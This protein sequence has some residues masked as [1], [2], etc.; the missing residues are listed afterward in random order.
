MENKDF[1][2]K[3]ERPEWDFFPHH[4]PSRSG[5]V[6]AGLLVLTIGVV[7]LINQMNIID[8]PAWIFSWK[9]LI[10]LIGL[11][12]GFKDS[13]R[14]VAWLILVMVGTVFLMEDLYPEFSV[15]AYLWPI[16]IIAIGLWLIFNPGKSKHYYARKWKKAKEHAKKYSSKEDYIDSVAVFGSVQKNILSK[17]FK[18]GDITTLFGGAEYNLSQADFEGQITLEVTQIFGGTTLII[19]AHWEVKSEMVA[20]FGGTEDKRPVAAPDYESG[21]MLMIKG[22]TIFGGLKIKS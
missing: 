14:N 21:K 5:R 3:E 19:P 12:I 13:F 22:T 9:V 10:I 11:F 18:G 1:D 8:L 4:G 15:R 17:T 16:I 6:L 2:K 20:V 7:L